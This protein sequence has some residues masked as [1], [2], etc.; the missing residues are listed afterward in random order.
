MLSLLR[1]VSGQKRKANAQV[2]KKRTN[3]NNN[4]MPKKKARETNR[5]RL[6]AIGSLVY[7]TGASKNS[8]HLYGDAIYAV[9]SYEGATAVA[10]EMRVVGVPVKNSW[11][12]DLVPQGM[13]AGGAVVRLLPDGAHRGTFLENTPKRTVW[14]ILPYGRK[15]RD[16]TYGNSFNGNRRQKIANFT[17]KARRTA[18]ISKIKSYRTLKANVVRDPLVRAALETDTKLYVEAHGTI[19]PGT[20][21]VPKGV[22]LVFLTTPT[23]SCFRGFP[24]VLQSPEDASQL[25]LG[26]FGEYYSAPYFEG[27]VVSEHMLHFSERHMGIFEFDTVISGHF[28]ENFK[29]NKHIPV[30]NWRDADP[31][32]NAGK[33]KTL[34]RNQVQ[35]VHDLL[36]HRRKLSAVVRLARSM[37]DA[38][39][40][41]VLFLNMC[42]P[43]ESN[44][45]AT[46]DANFGAHVDRNISA[47]RRVSG[48]S[49]SLPKNANALRV[50]GERPFSK[51]VFREY[52]R[53]VP[54][55][56]SILRAASNAGMTHRYKNIKPPLL[57]NTKRPGSKKN[58]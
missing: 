1:K 54:N 43:L 9:T 50:I 21:R 19:V 10:R 5:P 14:K 55:L 27:D 17:A 4:N 25:I 15:V 58:N 32:I 11:T 45:F 56:H 41:I 23:A 31:I 48:P 24:K 37:Y 16:V 13:K 44:M 57:K 3:N 52:E 38:D 8:M 18:A 29:R 47:R 42:R 35:M 53:E 40:T 20:F 36:G 26:A 33:M 7:R 28:H 49:Y 12:I 51:Y 39:D 6:P 22:C 30:F 46:S 34:P 2:T